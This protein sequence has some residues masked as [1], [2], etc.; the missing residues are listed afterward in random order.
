MRRVGGCYRQDK[1]IL[2]RP[3]IEEICRDILA[4]QP[5]PIP[6]KTASQF[7]RESA[8]HFRKAIVLAWSGGVFLFRAMCLYLH[9]S[10]CCKTLSNFLFRLP[11]SRQQTKC[12][13]S[14]HLDS[15]FQ[16]S[17]PPSEAQNQGLSNAKNVD[18]Q[19]TSCDDGD[20]WQKH[21]KPRSSPPRFAGDGG[22]P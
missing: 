7:S 9:C 18:A 11:V 14:D 15:K 6:P 19:I 16:D 4:S 1:P 8:K 21:S 12:G 3:Q 13:D 10:N 20:Q 22:Q 2:G 5:K 17:C